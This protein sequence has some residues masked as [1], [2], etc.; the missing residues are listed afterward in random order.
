M[1][2]QRLMTSVYL[3]DS[4]KVLMLYRQGSSVA[5]DMW[6][7]SAGGHFEQKELGNARACVL[8]ELEEEMGIQ[9]AQLQNLQLRYITLRRTKG[10]IRFNYYFFADLPGGQHMTL[11]SNEGVLRWFDLTELTELAMPYSAKFMIRHYLS[12]GRYNQQLYVGTA[13]GEQVIFH[14]LPET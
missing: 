6:I 9:E 5:S 13:N 7:G 1:P 3:C 14:P 11:S 10:E 12:Q 4:E 8:R 2:S